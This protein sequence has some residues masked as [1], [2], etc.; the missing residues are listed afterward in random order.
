MSKA[1]EYDKQQWSVETV[2]PDASTV[3]AI[4]LHHDLASALA[5]LVD[6]SIDSKASHIRI[7]FLQRGTTILGLQVIDNG[8]G[9][10]ASELKKAMTFGARREYGSSELGHFGLG[11]KVASLSQASS[12]E[13][14]SRQEWGQAVGRRMDH[15]VSQNYSVGVSDETS[16]NERLDELPGMDLAHGT[17]VEWI[18]LRDIIHTSEVSE[19][20]EWRSAKLKTI[21]EHLGITFHRYLSESNVKIDLDTYDVGRKKALPATIVDPI[22]P[23]SDSM[24]YKEYPQDFEIDLPDGT[25]CSFEAHVFP[26][27]TATASFN[28][29][30]EQGESRQGIFLYRRD[31]L[32]S[33]GQAWAGLRIPKKDLGL[34]RIRFELDSTNEHFITINPEKITPAYS[35]DFLKAMAGAHTSGTFP[36]TLDSYFSDLQQLQR[37]SKKPKRKEIRLVEPSLGINPDV[38]SQMD[39]LQDFAD[40][41]PIEIRFVTLPPSE[42]FRANRASRRIDV[43]TKFVRKIYGSKQ[44]L[45]NRDGQLLKT[46]LYFLLEEDFKV[47]QRWTSLREDK[48]RILNEVLLAAISEDFDSLSFDKDENQ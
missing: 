22:D 25:S 37:E 9:M 19:L 15:S 42:L 11:L 44:R 38:V 10:N 2:L 40:F 17:L 33:A 34:G 24:K 41:E 30:G 29:Y 13:V 35:A 1:N 47:E 39:R 12:F 43:S 27:G 23:F 21:R 46:F 26:A 7:R 20:T 14:Y 4:G 6:N 28:L 31:R 5:D 16:A 3:A 36:K 48:H 18:E 8:L 32:L 45:S